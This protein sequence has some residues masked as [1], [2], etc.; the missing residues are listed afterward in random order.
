MSLQTT[1]SAARNRQAS[2]TETIAALGCGLLF[3]MG[4]AVSGMIDP[5][6]V[7][8]FLDVA[9]NWDPALAFVMGGA[10][11]PSFLAYRI[12]NQRSRPM[13]TQQFH[14]PQGRTIDRRL[15]GGAILF[16]LGWGLVGLCP[17]PAIAAL[18]TG[19]WE[20]LLFC[21][22]MLAGMRLFRLLPQKG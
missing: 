3:G 11:I 2:P 14:V 13:L 15:I 18:I 16:G 1:I 6:K 4:L 9:G 5:A 21:A 19:K 17:G 22:A 8:G 7:L 20:I 10:L 12:Q